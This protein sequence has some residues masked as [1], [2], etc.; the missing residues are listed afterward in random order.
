MDGL[1]VDTED[2]WFDVETEIVERL[3]GSWGPE[4][5]QVMVGGPLE[6]SARYMIDYVG[7]SV[8]V[9][10][11]SGWLTESMAAR[12]RTGV[13][14]RPGAKELLAELAAAGVPCALVSSSHRV[15]VDVVLDQVGREHFVTT[16]AGDEVGRTKPFPDPY[17]LAAARLGV[18]PECCVVLEDSLTGLTAGEAAGCLTV[19]VPSVVPLPPAP[20]RTVLASL[21]DADPRLLAALVHAAA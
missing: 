5:H 10:T 8:S 6:V 14:W 18:T 16:V 2:D 21:E 9:E 19:G 3:G 7:A 15:L 4:H 20:R 13:R 11:L 12:L 17:L 1:L